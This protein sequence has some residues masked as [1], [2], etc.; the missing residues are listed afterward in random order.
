MTDSMTKPINALW[1]YVGGFIASIILTLL[2]YVSVT[3]HWLANPYLNFTILILAFL[4]LVVQLVCFLHLGEEA[5][6]RWNLIF[7][8][9]AA[10]VI[11]IVVAGSIWIMAHLNYNMMPGMDINHQQMEEENIYK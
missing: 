9:S 5:K 6:P 8:L 10:G 7:L 1:L 2:A 11:G 4:Q 3:Q